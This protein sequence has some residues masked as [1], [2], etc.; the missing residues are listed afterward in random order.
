MTTT[1][2]IIGKNIEDL[3]FLLRPVFNDNNKFSLQWVSVG[4]FDEKYAFAYSELESFLKENKSYSITMSLGG[5]KRRN[6]V[7]TIA[8]IEKYLITNKLI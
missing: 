5:R 4:K 3:M 6:N 7:R 8:T 1:R 2:G